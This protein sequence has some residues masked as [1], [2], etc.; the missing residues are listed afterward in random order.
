MHLR[1]PVRL[2]AAHA[3]LFAVSLSAACLQ[4]ARAPQVAPRGTLAVGEEGA[5]AGAAT[6]PFAVVF[7]APKGQTSDPPQVSL[8]WNRPMRPME[9]ADDGAETPVPARLVPEVKGRWRWVGTSGAVFAPEGRLPRATAFE[10]EVP[11]GTRALDGSTLAKPYVLEFATARPALARSD[12]PDGTDDLEPAA[13]VTLRF[14]QPID[15]AEIARAVSLTAEGKPVPFAVARPDP[16]NEMLAELAPRARLPL[17]SA[18]EL[19]VDRSLRGREGPLPAG[20]DEVVHLRTYGP[21]EVTRVSCD[22]DTPHR[23]CSASGGLSFDLSNRVKVADLKA[24]ITVEPPVK[25][26]WPAWLSDDDLSGGVSLSG[27][28]QPGK[29]YTVRLKAGIRDEHGQ[30]L[31]RDWVH[32]FATD[33]LWPTAEIGASGAYFEPTARREIPVASVNV[34]ELDLAVAALDEAG[35]L[36]LEGDPRRASRPSIDEIG[37]LPGARISHLTPAAAVNRRAVTAVRTDDALGGKDRRGP[38]AIGV[39]WTER[40]GTAAARPTARTRVLQVTDLGISAKVSPR[41]SVVWVTRLSTGEPVAGAEV[42]IRRPD[43]AGAP[44]VVTTDG[45]GLAAVDET[46][47]KPAADGSESGVIFAR[48][49]QDWAYRRVRDAITG[50]RFGIPTDLGE[51]RPFGLMFTDRGIYRPGD[52]VRVKAIVRQEGHPNAITPAGRAVTVKVLGPDGDP[53]AALEPSIGAFGT[54][55]VDVKVPETGRLGSYEIQADVDGSPRDYPDLTGEFEVAEYRPAEFAVSVASDRPSY[56]RG[57]KAS[58][59][60][61]GDYLYGAPMAGAGARVVVTRGDSAFTPPGTDGYATDERVYLADLDETS[62]RESEIE[63]RAGKL[64]ARGAMAVGTTLAMP[65]QRGPETVVC[66]AEVTDVSRQALAGRTAAIVHPAEVYVALDGGGAYFVKAGEA[67]LPK[68]LAVDPRGTRVAGV[69]VTVDL[70][71]RKWTLAR[72]QTRGSAHHT[73][74][75]PSDKVVASCAVTSAAA[76][77]SCALTPPSAGYYILHATAVDRRGNKVGAARSLYAT[78]EGETSWGDRDDM[79][80]ELVP[81]RASYEV[82]QTARV[83]VKSPFKSADALVTVERAGIYSQ[84]RLTLT[85]PMPTVEIPV[86]P[87][88]RPNAFVS[89][90]LLRGR[91]KPPPAAPKAPDVGA[92]AFRVGYAEIALSPA[93]R[94]LDVR[95]RANKPEY[96]PGDQVEVEMSVTDQGG[97]PAHAEI[98]LS[99]VDEGVLSLIGFKTPDPVAVF[100]ARRALQVLTVESRQDLGRVL[101]PLGELGLDKGLDGGGGGES[102]AMRRDFRASAYYSPSITTDAAGKA[103]A[104]FKLPD[105]LTTYRLMAVVASTDDRFGAAEAPLVTSRPLMARP[106][107]P[108]VVRAGDRLDAGVIVTTKGMLART[109]VDVEITAAGLF[110]TGE[111]RKAVELAPGDSTEVRFALEAPRVGPA[112]VRFKVKGGGAEDAVELTR[113]VLAPQVPEAVAL[114]G[115]TTSA[116]AEKLGDLGAIRTDVGGLEVSLSSTALV[117]LDDGVGQLLEYPYGCTEQLVSR[118]VPLL[119]LRDLAKDYGIK[120]PPDV[121]RVAARTVAAILA[122]QRGDGGFGLWGD[123][124][125]SSTFVTAYALWGLGEA[126]RR[127]LTVPASAVESATRYVRQ[128]LEPKRLPRSPEP[129]RDPRSRESGIGSAIDRASAAFVIDVLAG[130]GAPDAGRASRLFE[131]RAELPLFARALLLHAM[132]VGRSDPASIS[133]LATEIEAS[134]RIDGPVAQAVDNTGDRYAVLMDS[135]ARTSAMVLRGLLAARPDHPMGGRLAM[136]LLA[137]RRGGTWRSTQETAWALLALDAYRRVQEKVEPNF[138][139]RVFLGEAEI[140]HAEFRGRGLTEVSTTLPAANLASAGGAPLG[141]AVEGSGRLFYEARLRYA[142]KAMP[143]R[144]MDR[145]LYVKKTLRPVTADS[146][147]EALAAMPSGSISRFSG[148]DLVLGEIVVVTPAPREFVVVDDPLPAGFEAIDARLATTARSAD[149]DRAERR[150]EAAEDGEDGDGDEAADEPDDRRARG[151]A[152]EESAY[153]REIRDDRVLFFVDH[154]AAGMYRYRYLARATTHGTFVLPPTRAEQMYAPEVF[155]RSAA[156]AIVVAPRSAAP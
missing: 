20:A 65:G 46:R 88:L 125:E 83:L 59:S 18:I 41:G 137:A 116:S 153:V 134:L 104:S 109:K 72:Q 150:A 135:E 112:K 126:K 60:V 154:M 128:A 148:G 66:E 68:V 71:Q 39:G 103:H 146:L 2:R 147:P 100:T 34:A 96:R 5:G 79:A 91:T 115:D 73:V 130:E 21:L 61:R 119:P 156:D 8:V 28:F 89:V 1:I 98:T 3:G 62:A 108:R 92:P 87:D 75:T 93:S 6:G 113:E 143:S 151:E 63:S 131:E 25:L 33:D 38:V 76:P 52:V 9:L 99:A 121:D 42:S 22:D 90:L 31:A 124:T 64:D 16:K 11:A 23:R 82:G 12:P 95:L 129:E 149:V 19:K 44:D 56:V 86:T 37:R 17:A 84:R 138:D 141:F 67:V 140:Q 47:F 105:A 58:W 118:L 51:S 54:F 70:V 77:A 26:R 15:D 30:V 74:S 49:G 122:N 107:F 81:D 102:P 139:A 145:G 114:Y 36:A 14:D 111:A 32:P 45:N 155:G 4:G 27:R 48:L 29:R 53:I 117:G 50:W 7:G 152:Y 35:V 24:A 69:K 97:K 132:V 123:S 13:K 78:G 136:G 101:D 57:D 120:L 55:A 10:V 43:H 80:V 40:A 106:A 144:P 127:G 142:R 94:R 110:V 85:G 133:R